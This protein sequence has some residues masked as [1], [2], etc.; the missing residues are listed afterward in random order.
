MAWTKN[1]D[2]EIISEAMIKPLEWRSLGPSLFSGRIADI[3]IPRGQ[4]CIIYC[5]A[6]SGGIWKT[7]NRGTTWEPIFDDQGTGS[8]GALAVADSDP[9]IVWAGT[10]E[11]IAASH[12]TWGDGVYKS[13]DAGKTWNH[14]GLKET[15]QIGAVIIHPD[16]PDIVYV[17]AVG[18]LWGKN[19]ERGLYKTVDA[20]KNWEKSLFISD[21]VGIVDVV[22]DPSDSQTLYAAAYGRIRGPFS[23]SEAEEVKILEGSGIFKTADGGQNWKR[24]TKGLPDTRVGRIGL[25]IP[26]T[27]PEKIY[28]LVERAPY[29]IRLNERRLDRIRFIL[30]DREAKNP[31]ELNLFREF[32]LDKTP[33]N[34][35]AAAMFSG[36]DRSESLRLRNMLGLGELDTGGGLFCSYDKGETWSRVHK[37]SVLRRASYYSHIYVHPLDEN[38]L[39]IPEVRMNI[40]TDGGK[41]FEQAGWAFSSWLTTKFIHG[42]FHP[43]WIDPADPNH[44]IAGSDGGL[45]A[46]YD[47]GKNWEAHF[48]PIGQFHTIAVD[49][50]LP[51]YV[52]GGL[53]DNGGWAGPSA[54]RHFSGITNHDWFKFEQSDGAYIQIDPTDNMTVYSEWQNGNICRLDLRTGMRTEIKPHEGT[55]DTAL[56][57]NF[58][59]PFLL[60]SHDL[61]ILYLGAQKMMKTTDRGGSWSAISPDLTKEKEIA[62]IST[63]AESPLKQ[64]VLLAGTEDGNVQISQNDGST[65]IDVTDSI[66][67]LP[68]DKSGESTLCVSRIEAS[69]FDPERAYVS[70]DGH[71]QDDFKTYIFRT[72]DCGKTWKSVKGD[73]PEDLVVRVI[74]EDPKNPF[75]LFIGTDRGVYAS[76]DGGMHWITLDNGLPPVRVDDMVIHPRDADLVVGT[77]GRGIYTLDIA[78]LQQMTQEVIE[79]DVY[80]F[81][82][83]PAILYH[84]DIRKNKGVRG[85][86]WF[87]AKNPYAEVSDLLTVRYVLGENGALAPPGAAIYYY[88]KEKSRTPV[89]IKIFDPKGDQLIRRLEGPAEKGLNR[90]IWDLRKSST[91][92]SPTDGG[93][94]AVRL[95]ESGLSERPGSLVEP[96]EFRVMFLTAGK[97]LERPLRVDPDE[98]L[99][100]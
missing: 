67:A 4:S 69:H 52:Y 9:S 32:I 42:D 66:P 68:K 62:T 60:S 44:M 17:A 28:A 11:P 23:R 50:R 13:T 27:N 97:H 39:Y 3:A 75:L 91:V 40:S 87:S 6:A 70:F 38:T 31:K 14:M 89:E 63:I 46:S 95:R 74:R 25:A 19:P 5:A 41:T 22:M 1:K 57:F 24:L 81:N 83:Q 10:G 7:T 37:M 64:G 56:R 94:D 88:L 90:V 85:D 96:G 49:N 82:I 55:G 78:P 15:Q 33:E 58:I 43:L 8:M 93:N 76:I 54:T 18:H 61:N 48:M 47:G 100:F 79:A 30:P 65:W 71:R 20:G 21:S 98:Y 77:H 34:E 73:L 16:N 53:E 99:K 51:Y 80:L 72:D 35:R 59:T 36:F 92:F 29:E 86:R 84:L 45:Y 2:T 12:T 26:A